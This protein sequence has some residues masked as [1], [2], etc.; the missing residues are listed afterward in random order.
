MGL[1][2]GVQDQ[3]DSRPVDGDN[4]ERREHGLSFDPGSLA[5]FVSNFPKV[6]KSAPAQERH[7]Q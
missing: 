5:A 7:A 3:I 2:E 6:L 1:Y 4:A